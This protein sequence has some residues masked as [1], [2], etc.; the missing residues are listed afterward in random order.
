M[1]FEKSQPQNFRPTPNPTK[2]AVKKYLLYIMVYC[3]KQI[4]LLEAGK[5]ANYDKMILLYCL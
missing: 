2:Y 5:Y 1:H 3:W 4:G